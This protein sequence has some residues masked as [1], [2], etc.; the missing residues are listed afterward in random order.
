[1]FKRHNC[2]HLTKGSS[3]WCKL[4]ANRIINSTSLSIR[5][6]YAIL[7]KQTCSGCEIYKEVK[8][9]ERQN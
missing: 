6:K 2:P 8:Q 5:E 4:K 3:Y 7:H 9:N 1:M